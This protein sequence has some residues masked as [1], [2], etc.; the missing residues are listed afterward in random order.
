MFWNLE[1]DLY[2]Q[3]GRIHSLNHSLSVQ[4]G[5]ARLSVLCMRER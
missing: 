4:K 5:Y 1:A 2:A 3:S